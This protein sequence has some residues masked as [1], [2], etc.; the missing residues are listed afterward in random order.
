MRTRFT[1]RPQG[2]TLVEVMLAL[3]IA[4]LGIV[5]VLGLLPTGLQSSR[6]AADNTLSATIVQDAF[7]TLRTN[8][9][10]NALVC[11][12]CL[13]RDLATYTTVPGVSSVSNAYDQA[14]FSANWPNAYYK[15]VLDY[16]PQTPLVLTRVTATVIWPAKSKA[17]MNTNVFVTMIGQYDQ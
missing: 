1:G 11:D 3:A 14:G 5:A 8:A 12:T 13:T 15:V 10:H 16:Q 6:D 4:S 7:S 9:F 2:F 17:P